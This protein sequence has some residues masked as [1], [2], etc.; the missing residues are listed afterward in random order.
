MGEK[1]TRCGWN[2]R[3][4]VTGKLPIEVEHIDGNWT[5]NDPSNLTLLCPN[6]HALTSTFRAL[7]RG[8][9]REKRR[10]GRA[11]R[12]P[13]ASVPLRQQAIETQ[14]QLLADAEQAESSQVEP[15]PDVQLPLLPPA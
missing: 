11:N 9:G 4:P 15:S 10:G 5:N 1:C 3:H 6:C 2:E 12:M 14:K 8:K 7:N 13:A